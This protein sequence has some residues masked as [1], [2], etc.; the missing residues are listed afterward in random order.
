MASDDEWVV[1]EPAF[2]AVELIEQ[3]YD[4]P[5]DDVP[6]FS[7]FSFRVRYIWFRNWVNSSAGERL[8][9][10]P[11]PEGPVS[12]RMLRRT[13]ALELA[14][15]PGGVLAAKIAAQAY[16]NRNNRRLCRPP[17][18]RSSRVLAEVNKHEADRNLQLI[19]AEFHNYRTASCPPAPAHETSPSSSPLSTPT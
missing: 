11:I 6:L 19:L 3:L 10:A 7:R 9:L 18:W 16:R 4:D 12:L 17:G 15:R 2:R 8:G 14:Y 1:V 13:I 5:R